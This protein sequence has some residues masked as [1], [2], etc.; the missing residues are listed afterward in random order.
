VIANAELRILT[1][2]RK[3]RTAAASDKLHDTLQTKRAIGV[4]RRGM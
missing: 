3:G 2:E 1:E 4:R